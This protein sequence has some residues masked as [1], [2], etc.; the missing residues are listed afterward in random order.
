MGHSITAAV[1][2]AA[3]QATR[4]WPASKVC[5][6][7]LFPL[8]RI[9]VIVHLVWE[10][11]ECGISDVVIVGAAHNRHQLESLFDPSQTAPVK[12]AADPL[13]RQFEESLARVNLSIIE[14]T[15]RYGNGSPLRDAVERFG[16]DSCV[17]AFGD[18]VIIGENASRGL[19]QLHEQTGHPVMGAQEVDRSRRMQFGILESER[20]GGVDYITRIVEKPKPEETTSNLASFGRYLITPD[21]VEKLSRVRPGRDGE[22]WLVDAINAHLESGGQACVF[23]LTRG[24]WYTVGD[25]K[26]YAEAVQ[27][28]TQDQSRAT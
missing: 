9:P 17:Y 7:E 1:I 10:M 22:V 5:P 26:G 15:G 23:P 2:A 16:C 19:I 4:M 24:M 27:A 6:K 12:V 13:V 28:A 11:I 8:G 20:R 14:Q 25:P 18:D 21:I 3:G